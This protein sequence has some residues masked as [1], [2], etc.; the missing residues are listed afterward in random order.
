MTAVYSKVPAP[1]SIDELLV[2]FALDALGC[3][4]EPSAR[5]MEQGGGE[6]DRT[7][8]TASSAERA[9]TQVWR[10]D[11]ASCTVRVERT[12][13]FFPGDVNEPPS[14]SDFVRVDAEHRDGTKLSIRALVG[15]HDMSIQAPDRI[16]GLFS[17]RFGR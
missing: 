12:Q 13:T 3:S 11:S 4:Q 15:S 6:L 9:S 10:V 8:H 2:A 7:P 5:T 17:R 14:E 16:C 1:R